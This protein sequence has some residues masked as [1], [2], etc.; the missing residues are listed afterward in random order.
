MMRD[1]ARKR[2][3]REEKKARQAEEPAHLAA[4]QRTPEGRAKLA[5]RHQMEDERRD[6]AL[7][8]VQREA[9]EAGISVDDFRRRT[10]TARGKGEKTSGGK[11]R[12]S[13]MMSA[14]VE[15]LGLG[16]EEGDGGEEK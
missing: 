11:R 2:K 13:M 4:W 8:A 9:E 3:E 12:W 7:L 16:K 1:K 15:L 5:L 10:L 6:A 14:C